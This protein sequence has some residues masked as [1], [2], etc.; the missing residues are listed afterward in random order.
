ME[1]DSS[2]ASVSKLQ[3]DRLTAFINSSP[4]SLFHENFTDSYYKSIKQ[5]CDEL[6]L[7]LEYIILSKPLMYQLFIVQIVPKIVEILLRKRTSKEHENLV[8]N[9][10][11]KV[12]HLLSDEVYLAKI[13]GNKNDLYELR[14]YLLSDSLIS[15]PSFQLQFKF[16]TPK[17]LNL[18]NPNTGLYITSFCQH[19]TFFQEHGKPVCIVQPFGDVY[20]WPDEW[21][22]TLYGFN[23]RGHYIKL[24][25]NDKWVE[26]IATDYNEETM[27]YCIILDQVSKVSCDEGK[28]ILNIN[29]DDYFHQWS[30]S[31][32][33][34]R[35][36]S[37]SSNASNSAYDHNLLRFD[38]TDEGNFIRIWW[39]RYQQYYYGRI[40][41]YDK[42]SAQHSICYEDGDIRSYDMRTKRYELL[43]NIPN[44]VLAQLQDCKSDQQC[45]QIVST[46]HNSKVID[47]SSSSGNSVDTG[48][49]AS[50]GICDGSDVCLRPP[51]SANT[52]MSYHHCKLVNEYFKLNGTDNIYA[53]L[54]AADVPGS[55]KSIFYY[56]KLVSVLRGSIKPTIFRGLVWEVKEAASYSFSK[57][58]S[59]SHPQLFKDFKLEEFNSF[60]IELR[61]LIAVSNPAG[62]MLK[63]DEEIE[64]MRLNFANKLLKCSTIQKRFLGLTLIKAAIW[65]WRLQL[66]LLCKSAALI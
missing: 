42:D 12:I 48:D 1:S 44:E 2:H 15:V 4:A 45:A 17:V 55:S 41:S 14:C 22:K 49:I 43:H 60:C 53:S 36:I 39:D 21:S 32:N 25:V 31:T 66:C 59:I 3:F 5:F 37:E 16:I 63:T 19:G 34:H 61:Q 33:R 64:W 29:I 40:L 35:V 10:L 6:S 7:A 50:F 62:T 13:S 57:Y 20:I 30:D 9:I 23:A 38:H 65:C 46:W 51:P 56:A 18:I 8:S 52:V 58:D 27:L 26:G 54:T 11:L 24:F 28:D 47:S